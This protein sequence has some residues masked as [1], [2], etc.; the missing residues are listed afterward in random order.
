M[1][2]NLSKHL[3]ALWYTSVNISVDYWYTSVD[4]WYTSVNY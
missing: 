1:I 2:G 4:Y 3:S